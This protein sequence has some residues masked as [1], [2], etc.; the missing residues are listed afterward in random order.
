MQDVVIP[1]I[2]AAIDFLLDVAA[3][4]TTRH[5]IE[6][7]WQL[8]IFRTITTLLCHTILPFPLHA[9]ED[10]AAVNFLG[11]GLWFPCGSRFS[12][13]RCLNI[14]SHPGKR[15]GDEDFW[16]SNLTALGEDH[17]GYI[18]E[19][20]AAL[21]EISYHDAYD[22]LITEEEWHCL[23]KQEVEHEANGTL[24]IMYPDLYPA[25]V[26]ERSEQNAKK[27][28]IDLKVYINQ[29]CHGEILAKVTKKHHCCNTVNGA[30]LE[31]NSLPEKC[32]AAVYRD[33]NCQGSPQLDID[34]GAKPGC[35][36]SIN[37]SSVLVSC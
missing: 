32:A 14:H 27:K 33:L 25:P 10:I 20:E 13:Q 12:A 19:E 18:D 31:L 2:L 37:F 21:P 36:D 15:G 3:L 22:N 16:N 24:H 29:G 35:F 4:R 8:G 23:A 6:A 17:P 9:R 34:N 1:S 11:T 28:K 26:G 7:V 30:V 5:T